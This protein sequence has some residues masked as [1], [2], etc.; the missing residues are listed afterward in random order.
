MT[1]DLHASQFPIGHCKY[2]LSHEYPLPGSAPSS[3][4]SFET[5]RQANLGV[6][7]EVHIVRKP[8]C[9]TLHVHHVCQRIHVDFETD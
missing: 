2:F 9:S 3:S 7:W 8:G 5:H 1:I 4:I 6:Q